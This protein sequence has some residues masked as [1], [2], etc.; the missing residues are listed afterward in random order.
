ML[1]T[2][3]Q[4]GQGPLF[5]SFVEDPVKCC[6]LR[7]GLSFHSWAEGVPLVFYSTMSSF[8]ALSFMNQPHGLPRAQETRRW[9]AS[10]WCLPSSVCPTCPLC[11]LSHATHYS[12]LHTLTSQAGCLPTPLCSKPW[13]HASISGNVYW[14]PFPAS[15]LLPLPSRSRDAGLSVSVWALCVPAVRLLTHLPSDILKLEKLVKKPK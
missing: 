11:H 9:W 1:S 6:I 12:D 3:S 14:I 7:G 4:L 13:S 5:S 15:S 2:Y 10:F 8:P